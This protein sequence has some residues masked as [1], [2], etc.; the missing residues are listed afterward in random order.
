MINKQVSVHYPNGKRQQV[1]DVA[2][3]KIAETS[4]EAAEAHSDF[5]TSHLDG[6]TLLIVNWRNISALGIMEPPPEPL[7]EEQ[8]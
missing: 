6:G 3:F 1:R 8:P 5:I 7:P 2:D 4:S